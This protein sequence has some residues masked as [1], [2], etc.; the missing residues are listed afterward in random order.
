MRAAAQ[1][2]ILCLWQHDW[3]FVGHQG[4][5]RTH[6]HVA[7][8]LLCGLEAPLQLEVQGAWR[9]TR[10][11]LVAP[12]VPQALN[13]GDGLIL[14]AHF[15]PVTPAWRELAGH[16]RGPDGAARASADLPCDPT[17]LADARALL[18]APSVPIASALRARLLAR[19]ACPVPP[20][21]PRLL[22]IATRLREQLPDK[23][24]VAALA[25]EI[26]LSASRLTHL[27]RE[28]TGVTLRRFLLHLK[29]Q[30][31][32]RHW[33]EGMTVSALAAASG[34]YDQPH[35]VRTTREMFDALP[36]H[37]M[38]GGFSVLDC[39]PT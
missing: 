22:H 23:L 14:I 32:F 9:S 17:W 8:S 36:S 31:L 25:G 16:L 19:L 39:S 24:D 29:T 15:D 3:L 30:Q 5:N 10:L 2:G 18:A 35:L 28:Q 20:L 34:F 27:F 6:R 1:R 37:Y 21:D 4:A 11:A 12:D 26:D 7:A 33:R 13:P 38:A